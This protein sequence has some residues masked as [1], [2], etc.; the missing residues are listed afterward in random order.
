MG[1]LGQLNIRNCNKPSCPGLQFAYNTSGE[2]TPYGAMIRI[3]WMIL[4]R[5]DWIITDL[6][7]SISQ[8][9]C[10]EFDRANPP[11]CG[12]PLSWIVAVG[13]DKWQNIHGHGTLRA[14]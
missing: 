1:A 6:K 5:L 4:T 8:E 9:F 2:F 14:T 12:D 13:D 10:L 3:A 11:R 7:L